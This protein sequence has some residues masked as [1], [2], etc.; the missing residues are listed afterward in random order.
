[1][2]LHLK[3]LGT[4]LVL[5]TA[6]LP[7][8]AQTAPTPDPA[9]QGATGDIYGHVVSSRDNE[10]LTLVQVELS[11][12]MF[13]AITTDDGSFR[14]TGVPAGDYVLQS[15]TVGY[16]SVRTP[17]TLAAGESR[18]ID[19]VLASSTT[20]LTSNVTVS[21][22]V[23]DIAPEPAAAGFT[24]AGDER[25]NLA[26]V[27]ADDPL[28]AVQ[29]LPGVTSNNDFSSEFSIRGAP[30]SRVGLYLDGVLLHSPFHTTDGQAD[31]GSLTIFNGDL[32]EDMT[33]YQGAWPVRF[34][35]RTAGVLDVQ[36]R[37]GNRQDIHGQLSA[38]ASN[39]GIML[40]GPTSKKKRGA[41]LVDYR[42]SYLQYILNRI[43]FGDQP[44]LAF[45]FDD[46]Q[47]RFDYDLTP[48]HAISLTLLEGSSSVDRTKYRSKLGPNTVMTS[49]YRFTLMNLGSRYTP[50][51]RLLISNHLAW[52]HEN[53]HVANHDDAPL[54]NQVYSEFTWRGDA[55][56]IWRKKSTLDFGGQFREMQQDGHSTQFIFAPTITPAL[57]SSH[58]N[59]HLGGAYLQESF[60]LPSGRL[61]LAAGVRQDRHSAGGSEITSP[62]ASLSIQP[63][64]RTHL[65]FDWGT[66]GQYP[67]LN[68]FFFAVCKN[69]PAAGTRDALRSCAGRTHQ[70][71]HAVA[72]GVLQS[73]GSRH[74]RAPCAGSADAR[75]AGR[76]G[77]AR[78]GAAQ[79]A[80]WL[81][82]RT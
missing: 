45:A 39:A 55:T 33:L 20:K 75:R 25:K 22:D 21:E 28:R 68:Q 60:A 56:V 74:S 9:T 11:G 8:I 37:E 34:S 4:A 46:V 15:T 47:G 10:P 64:K 7:S 36:T 43:D 79:L 26:S 70:R 32:T 23:F 31:N 59:E 44:P 5:L 18:N 54:N 81:R 35:D 61:R 67:E 58:G 66:Y 63:V 24:L 14:I 12:T 52:S 53:G 42:K 48:R 29:S 72:C 1:M 77:A 16:Y 38:S 3:L 57:D 69:S 50:S 13:R 51:D 49:G 73:R 82:A 2:K 65:Q 71:P 6:A 76:A 41:W 27:L 30:F 80:T 62:Y 17:F 78:R 40:E 19:V